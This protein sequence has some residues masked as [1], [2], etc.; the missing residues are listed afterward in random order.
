[1]MMVSSYKKA[2]VL[3]SLS[4]LQV[5]NAAQ[6]PQVANAARDPEAHFLSSQ[7]PVDMPPWAIIPRESTFTWI[8]KSDKYPTVFHKGRAK[9]APQTTDL[10]KLQPNEWIIRQ[11]PLAGAHTRDYYLNPELMRESILPIEQGPP[12][13]TKWLLRRDAWIMIS[14]KWH[15]LCGSIRKPSWAELP[16]PDEITIRAHKDDCSLY[17]GTDPRHVD[18]K[19]P[20]HKWIKITFDTNRTYSYWHSDLAP[21]S[22]RRPG[23][24]WW[25]KDQ[26]WQFISKKWAQKFQNP[27]MVTNLPPPSYLMATSTPPPRQR[28]Q[29]SSHQPQSEMKCQPAV[30]EPV[31]T[32]PE[33]SS[34]EWEAHDVTV[35]NRYNDAPKDKLLESWRQFGITKRWLFPRGRSLHRAAQEDTNSDQPR[36]LSSLGESLKL[37]GA[38]DVKVWRELG[39]EQE[40]LCWRDPDDHTLVGLLKQN[41]PRWKNKRR[42]TNGR[43]RLLSH[44]KEQQ[45]KDEQ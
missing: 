34:K 38:S 40:W 14:E 23:H 37:P 39:V 9:G 25:S 24:N 11:E 6:D 36:V 32:E 31:T 13:I 21:E 19:F 42:Y 29:L 16:T 18:S 22:E 15:A 1:M 3:F 33:R 12:F 7:M 5:A 8:V 41:G 26:A 17:F 27:A 2:A 35:L 10:N 44:S 45:T 4:L 20:L 30:P 28:Q 43:R